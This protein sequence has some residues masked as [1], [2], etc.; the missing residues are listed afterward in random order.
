M[1][2]TGTTTQVWTVAL[3]ILATCAALLLWNRVRGPRA[4][5]LL[6]RFGLLLGSYAAT[7]LAVLISVN[8][9]YGGLI[10]SVSDLFSDPNAAPVHHGRHLRGHQG[11]GVAPG[12]AVAGQP[13]AAG[14][15]E[16]NDPPGGAGERAATQSQR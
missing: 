11:P 8:I 3:A 14:R 10:V 5:R 9:A 6:S 15:S 16:A 13:G 4:V 12:G 2:L 7:A 1:Q